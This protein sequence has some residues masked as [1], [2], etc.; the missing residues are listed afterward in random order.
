MQLGDMEWD[1]DIDITNES[2]DKQTALETLNT[3]LQFVIGLQGRPMTPEEKLLFNKI[4]M[5]AD[6]VSPL[7]LN[8]L[9]RAQLA[10][11]P[12]GGAAIN[13]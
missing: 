11:A 12:V 10:P 2:K 3:T 9:P 4:L 5:L 13:Q 6:G 1:L 8:Q 7:E